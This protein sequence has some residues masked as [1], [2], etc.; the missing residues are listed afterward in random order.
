MGFE[1]VY[2]SRASRGAFDLLATR[3]A[4]QLGVQVKRTDLPA[5]V[6]IADWKR[7]R[8]EGARLGWQWVIAAVA[9]DG[10]VHFLDPHKARVRRGITLTT[11]AA[12]DNVLLWLDRAA[13]RPATRGAARVTGR[14]GSGRGSRYPR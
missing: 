3:G 8:A 11:S 1:L 9:S 10:A 12:I 6:G 2:H 7:M 4:R 14:A 13:R 5:H